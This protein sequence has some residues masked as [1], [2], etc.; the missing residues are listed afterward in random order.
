MAATQDNGE[1]NHDG[2]FIHLHVHSA[3]SLAEGAI[4]VG[5][6]KDLCLEHAMPALAVTDTNNLFGAL[7]VSEVL[8]GAGIQPITGLQQDL[9]PESIGGKADRN[10]PLPRLVLLAQNRTGYGHLMKITS[11]AFLRSDLEGETAVSCDWLSGH[12]EGVIC[13]TG[14]YDGPVDQLLRSGA[15]A[16]ARA[17]LETLARLYPDRLYV[18]IQRHPARDTRAVEAGLLDL[19]Y[20]IGLPIVA[21]ND[22][23][24]PQADGQIV[25]VNDQGRWVWDFCT[26][27]V[28]NKLTLEPRGQVIQ[29]EN[30]KLTHL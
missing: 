22:V 18:E 13:L 3:Y 2:D 29:A 19:A 28:V 25:T 21:A 9:V 26:G 24:F 14:G 8:S 16:E 15:E 27:E 5:G 11:R 23:Y 4:P 30:V 20:S 7:E 6:L 17:C 1:V 12:T 10:T